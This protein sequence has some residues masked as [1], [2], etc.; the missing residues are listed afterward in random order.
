LKSPASFF[1]ACLAMCIPVFGAWVNVTGTFSGTASAC[2]GV[3]CLAAVPN[4]NKVI[5]GICGNKGLFASTDN[6]TSWQALGAS[7][8][9]SNPSSILFD[10]NDPNTFWETGIWSSRIHK[11]TDGGKTFMLIGANTSVTNHNDGLGVDMTDPQR[12][13]MVAGWHEG[14][15]VN[16]STDGGATWVSIGSSFSGWTNYPIVINSQTF[17]LGCVKDGIFRT[18][19]GGTSW[20]KVSTLLPGWNPLIASNGTIYWTASGNQAILKSTDQ[21]VTWTSMAKPGNNQAN[22]YT[23]MELPDGSIV[24]VG[25]TTLV[26]CSDNST[27]KTICSAFPNPSG[28]TLGNVSYNAGSGSFFI[29]HWDCSNAIPAQAIWKHDFGTTAIKKN[30]QE[31]NS[32]GSLINH[33]SIAVIGSHSSLSN[34]SSREVFDAYGRKL[35]LTHQAGNGIV[36]LR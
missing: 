7:T 6:G 30:R 13:T 3:Y 22:Y 23:P 16:K 5:V 28:L 32:S 33:H 17:I 31:I 29:A 26:Q 4:Q 9:W 14:T 18:T 1:L 24:A 20:T 15:G 12:K 25:Q 8:E 10:K 11:T 2:G 27:W 34:H 21:G 19:N 36:I 35:Q